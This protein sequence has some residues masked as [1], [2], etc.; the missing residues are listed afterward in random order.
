MRIL[1]T[2]AN[3]QVGWELARR[4]PALGELIA[5]DLA[6]L[7]LSDADAIR[8][9]VRELK[10][11]L[12]VNAVA[13]TAVDRAESE[14]ELAHAVNARAPAVLAEEARRLGALLVD[15]STDYVFDA[16]KRSPYVEDDP[17]NPLNVYGCTKLAGEEA[18]R[19]SGCRHLIFRASWLY[20]PRGRN[21]VLAI[22]RKAR[23]GE[24][25][26]VVGDQTGVPISAAFLADATLRILSVAEHS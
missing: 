19:A 8:R 21:F 20:A 15:Y 25:L 5:T 17:P 13:Y 26:R 10:P 14:P 18:V 4:L 2:G 9:T 22:A 11:A 16:E 24:P 7:D 1:L 6:A 23:A 12:I 3:G